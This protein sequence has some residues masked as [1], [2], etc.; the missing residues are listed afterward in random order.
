MLLGENRLRNSK[1]FYEE[2]KEEIKI[3][4]LKP[5]QQIAEIIGRDL[6]KLDDKM[7]INPSRMISQNKK[8]YEIYKR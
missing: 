1:A 6:I 8:G 5:M 4:A 3:R 2:H 7:N